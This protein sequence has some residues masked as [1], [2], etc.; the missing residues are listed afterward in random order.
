MF[1]QSFDP[2]KDYF[3]VLGVEQDACSSSLKRAYRQLA[4]RYHPD[5]S[6]L[7]DA[8]V[9]FQEVAEAYEVLT[10]H[11]DAYLSEFQRRTR[12]GS[13]NDWE[14]TAQNSARGR[15]S[16]R[17]T[18]SSGTR[19]WT[20]QPINGKDR[21]ISYPLTLRY[22]IRLLE[23]GFFFIPG[24][25]IKMKFTRQ[26]FEGK[27]FR[28]RGKGYQ[29]MFGGEPGD[30]LVSF[31]I[32]Q[33][34]LSWQLKGADIYGDV[35]VPKSLLTAGSKVQF[36]SPVGQI[37]LEVPPSYRQTEFIKIYNKGL[38]ADGAGLAGHLYA[39]LVAA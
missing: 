21:S 19:P 34:S 8:T 22:A 24:L 1:L 4:R 11:R 9:R 17:Q 25:K 27:T 3:A 29:G 7:Q 2:N 18:Y 16:W 5:V 26:A 12:S 30:F 36:E 31:R 6:D 33:D 15:S 28:L 13:G 10:K 39:R 23:Q 14:K 20:R 35:R 37:V 32:T 38:P